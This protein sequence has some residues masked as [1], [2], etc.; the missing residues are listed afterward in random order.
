MSIL[1]TSGLTSASDRLSISL[2][3]SS[4][5]GVLIRFF[6]SAIFLCLGAPVTYKGW[7]VRYSP[8][9]ATHVSAFG[10]ICGG[11]VRKGMM[12]L[13]WLLPC[14]QLLPSLPTSELGPSGADSQVGGFL[15]VLGPCGSLQ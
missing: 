13:A 2:S 12:L 8:G 5:S 10:A 9:G 14:F 7:S 15:Y 1:I 6:I 11:G 3:L 4:F